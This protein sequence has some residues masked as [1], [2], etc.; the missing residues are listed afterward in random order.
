MFNFLK[1]KIE[2]KCKNCGLYD[3]NSGLCGVVICGL[4]EGID[5]EGLTLDGNRVRLPV[6]PNDDCFFENTFVAKNDS[7]KPNVEQIRIWC[8]DEKGEKTKGAGIVKI[9]ATNRFFDEKFDVF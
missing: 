5:T 1:K 9:E 8:E 3:P 7:F 4:P 2:A 6:D